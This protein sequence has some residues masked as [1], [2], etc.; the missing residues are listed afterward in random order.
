MLTV[1]LVGQFEWHGWPF[2]LLTNFP[3]Q[4]LV[5]SVIVALAAVLTTARITL[6]MIAIAIIVNGTIVGR[7]LVRSARPSDPR[8]ASITVGHLNAQTRR[9]DVSALGDYLRT[10]RPAVFVVLDPVQSDVPDL[11]HAAPGYRV[12]GD[13][14]A[15]A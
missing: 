8:A 13:A 14:I 2:D 12:A 11:T 15:C 1:T 3:V 6:V 7:T 4:L 9:I 10:T 5:A